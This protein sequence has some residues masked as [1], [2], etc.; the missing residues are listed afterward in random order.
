[1]RTFARRKGQSWTTLAV[2]IALFVSSTVVVATDI[3]FWTVQI[4]STV[5]PARHKPP[6]ELLFRFN[7][8]LVVTRRCIYLL[9]DAIVVWR[10][11]V[12]WPNS[13]LAKSILLACM[14]CSTVGAILNAVWTIQNDRSINT[15]PRIQSL[16]LTVPL[17]GTNIIATSLVGIQV[18]YYRRDIKGSLGLYTRKSQVERVLV[19]LVESGCLYSLLWAVYLT[20]LLTAGTGGST[21]TNYVG[22]AIHSISGIHPIVVVLV[23]MHATTAEHLIDTAQVSH[24]LHF[25]DTQEGRIVGLSSGC[26]DLGDGSMVNGVLA[27]DHVGERRASSAEQR[28]AHASASPGRI[29]QEHEGPM[30]TYVSRSRRSLCD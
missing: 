18:W 13:R 6:T 8:I 11:W 3:A 22:T 23:V 19:L 2:I 5:R 24:A 14:C 7:I 26:M 20:F 12:L 9:S 1:M 4:P 16:A 15:L 30:M 21:V 27:R 10:A 17:L 25:V 28:S 29:D